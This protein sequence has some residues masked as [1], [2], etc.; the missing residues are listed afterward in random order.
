[1]TGAILQLVS[2]GQDNLYLTDNPSITMFN[3]IYRRHTNFSMQDIT[4]KLGNLNTFGGST[5][6][7]I[8]KLGDLLHQ[9]CLM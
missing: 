6:Y 7:E 3:T 9:M 1:M 2:I 8:E 5:R 4:H